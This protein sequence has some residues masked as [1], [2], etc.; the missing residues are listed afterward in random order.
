MSIIQLRENSK[1][2]SI[3]PK[4][5]LIIANHEFKQDL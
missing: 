4:L 5:G 2:C 3:G 1:M